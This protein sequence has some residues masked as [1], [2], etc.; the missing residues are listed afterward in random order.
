[1]TNNFIDNMRNKIIQIR[2][3]EKAKKLIEK[4]ANLK[5]IQ[6]A[7][8]ARIV[9]VEDAMKFLRQNNIEVAAT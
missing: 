6:T 2:I 8:Y 3:D 5:N 1:M 7:T 4:V 9:L